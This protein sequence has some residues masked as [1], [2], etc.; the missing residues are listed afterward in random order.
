MNILKTGTGSVEFCRGH[1]FS[2]AVD[3]IR[4]KSGTY[5]IAAAVTCIKNHD[6]SGFST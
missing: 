6:T 1:G 3:K 2:Y 4:V 5:A